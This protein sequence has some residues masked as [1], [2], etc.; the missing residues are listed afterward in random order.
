VI[1]DRIEQDHLNAEF[2]A[3]IRQQI[4]ESMPHIS[5]LQDLSVLKEEYKENKFENCFDVLYSKYK[6]VRR[7]RRDGSCFYRSFLFQLF[8][9]II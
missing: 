2:E 5:E 4:N 9:Y 1:N 6:N 3:Q 7:M 8:E